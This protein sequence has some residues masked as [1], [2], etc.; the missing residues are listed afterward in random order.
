[1]L[2]KRIHLLHEKAICLSFN[3][4]IPSG[5]KRLQFFLFPAGGTPYPGIHVSNVYPDLLS[6]KRME[7]PIYCPENMYEYFSMRLYSFITM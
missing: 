7:P 5:I 2:E 6:G 1:M 3:N 4:T